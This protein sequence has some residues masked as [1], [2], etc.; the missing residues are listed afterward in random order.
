MSSDE[1]ER[2]ESKLEDPE[3]EATLRIIGALAQDIRGDWND[4]SER[5]YAMINLAKDIQRP[6]L[7]DWL[8]KHKKDIRSDGRI[9]RDDW[10]GP[11]GTCT[12]ADLTL[13]DLPT[14]M[15]SSPEGAISDYDSLQPD[16]PRE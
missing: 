11:Y 14:F 2:R 10:P 4:V 15:F 5:L 13:I 7:A 3:I 12:R 16:R 9:F 1:D 6:D 8:N